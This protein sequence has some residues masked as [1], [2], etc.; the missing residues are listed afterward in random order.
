MIN[1]GFFVKFDQSVFFLSDNLE[2]KYGIISVQNNF[3]TDYQSEPSD[4]HI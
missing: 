4:G 2:G 1:S 3:S